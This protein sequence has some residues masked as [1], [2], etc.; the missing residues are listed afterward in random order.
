MVMRSYQV[1]RLP[2]GEVCINQYWNKRLVSPWVYLSI[3][4]YLAHSLHS[5]QTCSQV[6]FWLRQFRHQI[7]KLCALTFMND[8]KCIFL[9]AE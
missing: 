1:Y 8:Q 4:Q 9:F 6:Q 3:D 5:L 7:K 2:L